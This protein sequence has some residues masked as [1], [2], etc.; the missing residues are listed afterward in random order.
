MSEPAAQNPAGGAGGVKL[1]RVQLDLF[2]RLAGCGD[3]ESAGSGHRS[4]GGGGTVGRGEG[5]LGGEEAMGVEGFGG[6]EEV[7]DE[8]MAVAFH[9]GRRRCNS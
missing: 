8:G 1:G 3:G 9:A 7:G 4:A 5:S 2:R 6:V